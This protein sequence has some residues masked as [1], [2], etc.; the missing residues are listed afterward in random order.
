M[1]DRAYGMDASYAYGTDDV[2]AF[3]VLY[4]IEVAVYTGNDYIF[5]VL[6]LQHIFLQYSRYIRQWY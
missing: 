6:T 5:I 3:D 1:Q 2:Q 4:G